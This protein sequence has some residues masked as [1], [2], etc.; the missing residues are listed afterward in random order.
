MGEWIPTIRYDM[1]QKR[2]LI[3]L[4]YM[5]KQHEKTDDDDDGDC[6]EMLVIRIDTETV[7]WFDTGPEVVRMF[8]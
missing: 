2:K 5:Q 1:T 7:G 6:R 3:P 8:H 4:Q